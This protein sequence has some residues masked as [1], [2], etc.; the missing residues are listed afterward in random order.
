M[1][2]GRVTMF[3]IADP[4]IVSQSNV[5]NIISGSVI[6]GGSGSC[7][8]NY[9]DTT[10]SPLG[11]W[12]LSGN[13]NDSSGI[14]NHHIG[15]QAGTQRYTNMGPGMRGAMFDGSTLFLSTGSV[16]TNM[17]LTGAATVEFIANFSPPST[18]VAQ[19]P[20]QLAGVTG[21]VNGSENF[22][23]EYIVNSTGMITYFA[24]LNAGTN[25]QYDFTS[26]SVQWNEVAHY[27]MTRDSSGVV[28]VYVNGSKLE[29]SLALS[30]PNTGT[31]AT[32]SARIHI[33]AD[34]AA[35]FAIGPSPCKNTS[36]SS[37]KLIGR[38]L[39]DEEVYTEYQR[40]LG[41]LCGSSVSTGGAAAE[42][43]DVSASYVVIGTTSSLPNE[44]RLAAG[45]G[46]SIFDGGPNGDV[47][48]STTGGA[49][50]VSASYVV[51]ALTSSLANERV[52]TV[53]AGLTLTDNGPNSSVVIAAATGS[54]RLDQD[55]DDIIVWRL[56][57]LTGSRI[58]NYGS[59]GSAGDI[60][61][62]AR[63]V[64][65]RAGVYDSAIDFRGYTTPTFASGSPGVKPKD[66]NINVSAWIYPYQF[67]SGVI[68]V[69]NLTTGT[70]DPTSPIILG[71]DGA[72]GYPFLQLRST[73]TTSNRLSIATSRSLAL[74]TWNHLGF[75]LSGSGANS[76]ARFYLNGDFISSMTISGTI[77]FSSHGWWG[78]GGIPPTGAESGDYKLNEIRIADV[79]RNDQWWRDIYLRG[80]RGTAFSGSAAGSG[81][82]FVTGTWR[83][84]V[85][86]FITTGSVS[87]DSQNRTAAQIGSD[88]FFFV[89][90]TVDRTGTGAKN[91][92]FGG[93]TY[94]SGAIVYLG[95]VIY[96]SVTVT[97]SYYVSRDDYLIG[98]QQPNGSSSIIF[99]PTG[100][101]RQGRA[102]KISDVVGNAASGS[103]TI[104][105]SAGSLILGSSTYQLSTNWA[106]VEI[107]RFGNNWIIG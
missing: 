49:G 87:I 23:F 20:F 33:G 88:V 91:V 92:L 52:L 70:Y 60:T 8:I 102:Y 82:A 17:V 13:L 57:E 1:V 19:V 39:S 96:N 22:L 4:L 15:L 37:V 56:N 83:D 78:V 31:V 46:I 44:R 34:S 80:L 79:V 85:N 64:Y 30:L 16:P 11:L 99:T 18:A 77:D 40:T 3:R 73:N 12:Q 101:I 27:A 43:A 107:I 10:Y 47:T 59:S 38:Q 35:G 67:M 105:G 61:G 63:L 69:K 95:G 103:I 53:G 68:L 66:T 26:A 104:S 75:S 74:Y 28:R 89:S 106:S 5:T 93:D 2:T 25:I 6:S 90:G 100:S 36:I 98:V 55:G 14:S 81:Q 41:G 32:S 97:G 48:I 94:F 76:V 45:T 65:G 21:D 86:T 54:T 71:V 29:T 7:Q 24:E 84:G 58:V 9:H 42:G 72:F 50:E 51:L 62:S